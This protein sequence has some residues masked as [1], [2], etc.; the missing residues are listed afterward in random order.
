M[1]IREDVRKSKKIIK[2]KKF[3]KHTANETS[4]SSSVSSSIGIIL[5]P[6]TTGIIFSSIH[7]LSYKKTEKKTI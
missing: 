1:T 3:L 2:V 5:V 7:V 4:S 6:W